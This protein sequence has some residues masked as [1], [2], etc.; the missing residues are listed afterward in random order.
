MTIWCTFLTQ[1]QFIDRV[2]VV[3]SART[4]RSF[5]ALTPDRS[6]SVS[7]FFNNLFRPEIVQPLSGNSLTSF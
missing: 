7:Q 3:I 4:A 2:N 5:A 1:N 6:D